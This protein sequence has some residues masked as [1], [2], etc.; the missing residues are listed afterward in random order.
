TRGDGVGLAPRLDAC[1]D[2]RPV[3]GEAI[4]VAGDRPRP[5]VRVGTHLAVPE[6]G[7]VVGFRTGTEHGLLG[8]D[9][10]PEVDTFGKAG[11]GAQASEGPDHRVGAD[12][13]ALDHR[14]EADVDTVTDGGVDEVG[15]AVQAAAGAEA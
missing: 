6:V 10:V 9:E 15:G 8:L 2:P 3:L 5:D 4:V 14:R 1:A 12:L 11:T 7:E 13:G